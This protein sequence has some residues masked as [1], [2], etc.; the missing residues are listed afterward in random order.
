MGLKRDTWGRSY[1]KLVE[2]VSEKLAESD[3]SYLFIFY[4]FYYYYYYYY[5]I[6]IF[7]A[8]TVSQPFPRSSFLKYFSQT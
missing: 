3:E 2:G 1:E 7:M 8:V 4:Y 5:F 6:F